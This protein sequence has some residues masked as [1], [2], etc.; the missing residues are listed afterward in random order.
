MNATYVEVPEFLANMTIATGSSD[1]AAIVF[2]VTSLMTNISNHGMVCNDFAYNIYQFYEA[3]FV[4][5][6]STTM[7][8][9]AFFS[10]VLGQSISLSNIYISIS[11]ANANGDELAAIY[12]MGRIFRLI[13]LE[14]EPIEIGF[15]NDNA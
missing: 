6:D 5:Y 4:E 15:F 13:V 8:A 2:N 7:L 11:E 12:D 9:L 3:N 14:F 10:N 1:Y